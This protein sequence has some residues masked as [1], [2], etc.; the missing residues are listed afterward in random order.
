MVR[1]RDHHIA[2]VQ[3][4]AHFLHADESAFEDG[5]IDYLNLPA[6]STGLRH[7]ERIGRDGRS[8]GGSRA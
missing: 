7:L 2:S 8:T 3:A 5:T 6:V 4:D 1:R